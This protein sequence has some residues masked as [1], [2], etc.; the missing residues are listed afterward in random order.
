MLGKAVAVV[1]LA[2]SLGAIGIPPS[3][4]SGQRSPTENSPW[5]ENDSGAAHS[6]ANLTETVLTPSTV[7]KARYL[8]GVVSP[9]GPPNEFCGGQMADPVLVG[10]YLYAIA[11][12]RVTKYNAATGALIWQRTPDPTFDS[13][14]WSLDV[15]KDTVVVGGYD[16]ESVSTPL[17][18]T[19]AYNATT[20]ALEWS[21][22]GG[23]GGY[24]QAVVVRPYVV[25]AGQDAAGYGV[26]VYK[27]SDGKQVWLG[28]GCLSNGNAYP[29]VVG[30]V[31]IG[32]N[33]DSQDNA[34]IEAM[35]LATGAALWSY[36]GAWEIQR[37]DL[38]SSSGKHVYATNPSGKV[39]DLD[40][41]TGQVEYSLSGAVNVL[42][43]DGLRAYATCGTRGK[44]VCAYNIGTGALEWQ[45]KRLA[46]TPA[47][48]AEAGGVLYLDFGR[49]L[50]AATGQAL[51]T[52]WA[53]TASAIAVGDGRIAV[54]VDPRVCD[55]YGL[56][57]Y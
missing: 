17:D 23:G 21:G 32:Y 22:P 5:Y 53:G 4:A 52:L 44:Y 6:R 54:V 42:A 27:L 10:G 47:L 45:D 12:E 9:P 41:L 15:S 28:G 30:K 46:A 20:G 49:A 3:L 11:N 2:A 16:C 18:E 31:V 57:G 48:A 56:S 13:Y 1:A 35:N 55:L 50:N 43:V 24:S 33:C 51:K 40:P 19:Y 29:L 34:N 37:G 14:F 36:P 7:A 38:S 26:G 8:R 39:V 25:A